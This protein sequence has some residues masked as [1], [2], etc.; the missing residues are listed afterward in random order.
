MW[1]LHPAFTLPFRKFS[2]LDSENIPVFAFAPASFPPEI[3]FLTFPPELNEH[4]RQFFVNEGPFCVRRRFPSH[5]AHASHHGI[6]LVMNGRLLH[7]ADTHFP[8]LHFL[9]PLVKEMQRIIRDQFPE[10][11]KFIS[12]NSIPPSEV[13]FF[14]ALP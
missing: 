1:Q 6:S 10:M 2:V 7:H 12:E 4:H 8:T 9:S 11:W 14:K 3:S 13:L 5:S